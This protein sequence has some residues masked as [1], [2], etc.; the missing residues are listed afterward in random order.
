MHLKTLQLHGFKSF[1]DETLLEFSPGLTAIVGFNGCGK[2]NLSDAI[3]WGLGHEMADVLFNGSD[4]REASSFAGARLT[5][6]NC[7]KGFH[8]GYFP[9][10]NLPGEEV[11]VMRRLGRTGDE[12][13]RLNDVSCDREAIQEL[14]RGTGTSDSPCFISGRDE[15]EDIFTF[16]PA[17][18]SLIFDAFADFMVNPS[19]IFCVLDGMDAGLND[20]EFPRFRKMLKHLLC[21]MQVVLIPCDNQTIE[22]ADVIYEVEMKERGVSAIRKCGSTVPVQVCAN[23][24]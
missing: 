24:A 21:H 12:L 17:D 16:T 10:M 14:F 9:G 7:R 13:Y 19:S 23:G 11:T 20:L 18:S 1:S 6:G 8:A 15:L 2:S 22:F 5:F 4:C 3:R